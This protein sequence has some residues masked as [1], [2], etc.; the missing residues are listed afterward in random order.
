MVDVFTFGDILVDFTPLPGSANR[1]PAYECNPGG[2][3][4][5]VAAS[6]SMLG[7]KT[8]LAG[9]VGDEALGRY[10]VDI[11]AG[12][13]VDVSGIVFDRQ[14]FTT[15]TFIT[16]KD[17]ERDFLI[18]RRYNADIFFSKDDL[19]LDLLAS[20]KILHISG[21]NFTNDPL[22]EASFF[23]LNKAKENEIIG[24]L[25]LNYRP[26]LWDSEEDFF[27]TMPEVI[28]LIDVYK[29]SDEETLLL[30]GESEMEKA[31]EKIHLWGPELVFI[32]AGPRGA[33]FHYKEESGFYNTY[34]TER[35]DTTGAGDCF[36]G[37]LL[38]RI[39]QRGGVE[40]FTRNELEDITDFANAAG[41]VSI[42]GR[43]GVT[44]VPTITEIEACRKN[45][46]KLA[47]P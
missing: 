8:I 32:T 11:I 44:S 9:R 28:K 41:A 5:N 43:G 7:L 15:L 42:T 30:T 39:I 6:L 25:D 16:L 1:N 17:G 26:T 20:S 47:A 29:G 27:H 19:K 24:T 40:D 31:A 21:A 12:K 38:Y 22:R 36:M 2:T 14:R 37:A 10:V 45:I 46:Q 33:Y 23:A 18:S 34:N 4:A 13:G 35:I 3:I